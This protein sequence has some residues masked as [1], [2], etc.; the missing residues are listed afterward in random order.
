MQRWSGTQQKVL[1]EFLYKF[2]VIYL[3]DIVIYSNNI[4]EHVEHVRQVFTVLKANKLY[5]WKEKCEF[6]LRE[7]SFLSHIVGNGR[8]LMDP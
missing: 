1:K 7:I 4:E 8:I 3:D 2:V 5:V 6:D